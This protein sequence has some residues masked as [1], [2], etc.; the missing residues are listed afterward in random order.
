MR[1]CTRVRTCS[2]I[3]GSGLDTIRAGSGKSAKSWSFR[4]PDNAQGWTDDIRDII[5]LAT[6][7][8]DYVEENRKKKD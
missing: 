5:K 3:G 1:V 2:I 7:R 4:P 6:P 8:A